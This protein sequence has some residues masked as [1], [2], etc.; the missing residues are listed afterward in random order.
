MAEDPL[1]GFSMQE[2]ARRAGVSLRSVYRHFPGRKQLFEALYDW[3]SERVGVP[4][5]VASIRTLDDLPSGA[6]DLF[7]RFESELPVV[8]A[9]VLASLAL[10]TSPSRRS[11]WD[12][13]VEDVFR[14]AL[15][16]LETE[17]ARR[18]YAMLRLLFT[19]RVWLTLSD[20]FGLDTP[21]AA[22]AVEWAA[23]TLVA[24]LRRRNAEQ[25]GT[26]S[27]EGGSR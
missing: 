5:V 3:S 27:K 4:S 7:A 2:V 24:D 17:Q 14:D 8:R 13:V 1:L 15:P 20:R 25:S 12:A 19:S 21:S 11:D 23:E 9:G 10:G 22:E 26:K 6:K 16:D 18:G